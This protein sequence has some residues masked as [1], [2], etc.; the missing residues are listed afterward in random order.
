[1][2]EDKKRAL[3]LKLFVQDVQA[4]LNTAVG[5]KRQELVQFLEI[6]LGK[7]CISLDELQRGQSLIQQSLS[8][9]LR[10]LRYV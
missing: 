3:I 9:M 6:L 8:Q 7:Y 5:E 2:N 10:H 4:G 1:M